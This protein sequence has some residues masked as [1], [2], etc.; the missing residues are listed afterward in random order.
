MKITKTKIK[1][2]KQLIACQLTVYQ[3]EKNLSTLQFRPPENRS[4]LKKINSIS[5]SKI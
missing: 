2:T 3:L 5:Q 4:E 1:P